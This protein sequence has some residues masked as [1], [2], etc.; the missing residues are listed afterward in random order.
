MM[1]SKPGN[2]L[3]PNTVIDAMQVVTRISEI[4]P[5]IQQWKH[6]GHTVGFVPTMGNLHDGHLRLIHSA[7][8]TCDKV[9]ASIFVNPTQFGAGEDFS[10]YPRTEHQDAEIL[11]AAATD[12]LFLPA[13]HEM[14][15]RQAFISISVTGL[16]E[17]H[18]GRSRP[19]HFNGVVTVV[20]KLFN[21]IEPDSAFFGEKDFQQLVII[22]Q[23]IRDLNFPVQICSVPIVREPDGLAMSSRNG[24]LT[25]EQRKLAPRLYH[26]LCRM[27]NA[28]SSGQSD[29]QALLDGQRRELQAAGFEPDYLAV[30]NAADLLEATANDHDLV[31]LA[32]AWLGCT[33]L[34][35][36]IRFSR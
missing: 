14:Y 8:Q 15:P 3:P 12:L 24:Y 35:D 4:R 30:C 32:A 18:C 22:Q 33:R 10:S 6:Q 36:N 31:I 13:E 21:I 27:R 23:M 9:V 11:Q 25:P 17:L 19:G 16:S 5:V 2:I 26:S 34:I 29:F 1:R 20:G 28:I 7:R